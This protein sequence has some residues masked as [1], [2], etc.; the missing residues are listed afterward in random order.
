M[1]MMRINVE[2]HSTRSL[3][4][5][6]LINR[7]TEFYHLAH[8]FVPNMKHALML[9][10]AGYSFPQSFLATYP[11]AHIDVVEI[12]PKVTELARTYF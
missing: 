3:V 9:G 2:N 4:S 5:D 1:R 11:D 12:D 10:G 6:R 7:Y 8:H